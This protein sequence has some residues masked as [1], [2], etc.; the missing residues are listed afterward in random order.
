MPHSSEQAHL[1]VAHHELCTSLTVLRLAVELVRIRLRDEPPTPTT[2]AV[3]VH[4]AD[5]DQALERLDR[6][7]FAI[8]ARHGDALDGEG[9][10]L[11]SESAS[12]RK[13]SSSGGSS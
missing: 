9:L 10:P 2:I 3:Q 13:G 1:E 12:E 6:V 8:R 4:L 11:G 5:A 7:A